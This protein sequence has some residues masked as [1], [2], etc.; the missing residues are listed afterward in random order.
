MALQAEESI[1]RRKVL[2]ARHL[3]V[4]KCLVIALGIATAAA[5][6]SPFFLGKAQAW[7]EAALWACWTFFLLELVLKLWLREPRSH[8]LAF[9]LSAEGAVD[10][11]AIIP[12]PVALS[13]GTPT[14][15]AWLL[16]SLWILK[17]TSFVPGFAVVGRI[18]ALEARP[19]G[20]VLIIFLIVL[21]FASVALFVLERDA[22]P[23]HFGSLPLSFWW[24]VTTL[25]TTGYGDSVPVTFLGRIIAGLVMICG[26]GV[27]GMWAGILATGFASEHR[28]RDFI[29]NWQFVSRVPLFSELEPKATIEIARMLRL[30]HLAERTVVLKRGQSG[31][32]M[33]FIA[34][35]EVEVR[36]EPEP[37][38][39]GAG[40]FFGEIALLE[41][42][43]R[44]ATV[45]TTR[46]STLLV[47]EVSDFRA[48]TAVHP[49]I[50]EI[51]EHEAAKRIRTRGQRDA[52]MGR[53]ER[54]P[55]IE[56]ENFQPSK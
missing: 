24:A 48:F 17:L 45:V 44:T 13:I 51:I 10:I 55:F 34:E 4:L 22:Q 54:L 56:P 23:T 40:Q 7:L 15:A 36:V 3:A 35:G 32:C 33:Y 43:L 6:T 50:A 46:P 11:L 53:R 12:V 14:S 42:S 49:E 8:W 30:I 28:R 39:L 26:L 31:D 37:V 20:S 2:Q 5:L 9:L 29:R 19:L 27:F 47:L 38:R 18:I 41:S 21:V 1:S 25:T 52:S 16:A